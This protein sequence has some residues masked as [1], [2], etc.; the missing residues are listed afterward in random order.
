MK[1]FSSFALAFLFLICLSFRGSEEKHSLLHDPRLLANAWF[2]FSAE[3]EA[4]YLQTFRFAGMQLDQIR[5]NAKSGK[6][7]AIVTDLDET[8]LDNS[9]WA[10]RV[11]RE[12][13]DYPAYWA[14]WEKAGTAPAFPGGVDFFKKAAGLGI[15]IYYISN[16]KAVNL[17][18]TLR[19]LRK[20]G[21]PFADTAHIWLKTETSNKVARRAKV[22][23]DHDIVMLLGDNLADF[24]AVWE[25]ATVE[26]RM[27][28]VHDKAKE[29][30]NRFVIFP[31]PT[32]GGWKDALFSYQRNLDPARQDSVW[33]KHTDDY[34]EA[35]GFK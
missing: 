12:G 10:L 31:N 1:P 35:S 3:K 33:K 28:A 16:R 17:D 34:L 19:N 9:A 22:L 8:L 29:W 11:M 27:S 21:L 7:P 32:Y 25:D 24:D 15:D 14:E 20:L 13:K 26:K 6:K 30:G 18:G 23:A 2:A 4:C 5:K